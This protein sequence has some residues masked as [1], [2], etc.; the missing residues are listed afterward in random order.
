MPVLAVLM[1]SSTSSDFKVEEGKARADKI[2]RP[3]FFGE[4]RVPALRHQF[5]SAAQGCAGHRP[6]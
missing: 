5:L 3:V 1:H 4:D 6:T 2:D